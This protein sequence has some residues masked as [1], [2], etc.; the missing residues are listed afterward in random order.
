[1]SFTIDSIQPVL[2]LLDPNQFVQEIP[3]LEN[4]SNVRDQSQNYKKYR[5]SLQSLHKGLL[6]GLR[7]VE[8][9]CSKTVFPLDK[10]A[11]EK[12][13]DSTKTVACSSVALAEI[14]VKKFKQFE[15]RIGKAEKEVERRMKL[16]TERKA[17]RLE[18]AERL[19]MQQSPELP[20]DILLGKDTDMT[21]RRILQEIE[22]EENVMNGNAPF[23]WEDP[24]IDP[25]VALVSVRV[26]LTSSALR[27]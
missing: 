8:D 5:L 22:D 23:E 13:L 1:M 14:A 4:G 19:K 10:V 18:Q 27:F 15:R 3:D 24:K 20:R 26:A 16:M 6:E 11:K 2:G 7:R 17:E 25:M 12:I 21:A 9:R